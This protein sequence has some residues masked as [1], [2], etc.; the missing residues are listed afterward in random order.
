MMATLEFQKNAKSDEIVVFKIVRFGLR[1]VRR[2]TMEGPI[3]SNGEWAAA[4]S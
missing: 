3:A 4:L 1:R 2:R